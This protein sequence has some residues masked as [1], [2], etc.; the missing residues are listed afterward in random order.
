[1]SE[2]CTHN[3]S[4]CGKSC[5]ERKEEFDFAAK[6]N[7]ASKV[8]RVIAVASGKGGVGKSFVSTMLAVAAMRTAA[9][10]G[11]SPVP[12]EAVVAGDNFADGRWHQ[13]AVTYDAS[14]SS[15]KVFA[16]YAPVL[17]TTLVTPLCDTLPGSWMLGGGCGLGSFS[18]LMDEVRLTSSV[19][20]PD[21]FLHLQAPPSTTILFR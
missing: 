5:G 13:A 10:P 18:G 9:S 8:G 20:A 15:L 7:A 21:A 17:M 14:T 1:M 16:D 19:L 6:L 4:T 12:Y 11:G 2:E 3:C